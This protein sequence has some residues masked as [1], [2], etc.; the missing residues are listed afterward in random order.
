M[1]AQE[2]HQEQ[3]QQINDEDIVEVV[4]DDGDDIGMDSD[5][6]GDNDKY[7]GEIIIGGPGPGEEDEMM[8][9]EE[10]GEGEQQREDNSVGVN[11]V[12]AEGQ[13][14]FTI[15]LHP[16]FPNPPLAISGGEDDVGFIFCPI[17][18]DPSG[19]LPFTSET[20]TPIKLDGHSDS[21]VNAA[22]NF[23]GEMVAT[24]G[25]DG[26]VVVWQRTKP[27]AAS[28]Q[29]TVEEWSNWQK[30][31][32]LETGT[33]ISWLQWHPKGNVVAA[34]C[35]DATVW[36][37]NLP[38]GNTLNVL[39]AHTMT[40]TVG[41]FTPSGKQLLT[42]SIDSSLILWDPREPSPIWKSSIF[43]PPNWPDLDPSE[44]G[45]TALAVS[46][47]GQIAAVG[48]AG[49]Q[50]KLVGVA[51]GDQLATKLVG[52]AEGESVE[53]LVFVDL[54]NG[55]T[56]GN[57]GVVLVSAATDGKA[58][59]WDVATG[60]V[61]A[62]LSHSEPIT[63]VTAHPFP[64]LHLV[65]TASADSTLKTWDIRTG[66]LVGTHTGHMGVVNGVA[67]APAPGGEGKALVSAGDEGVSLIWKL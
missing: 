29:A 15:A 38:S 35:E 57:K 32:E 37:W 11:S 31:Q 50:V 61:R 33:E 45:I 14:V 7:D 2:D 67:V 53:A 54:L 28:E 58:F 39:S 19:T 21:V 41:L 10:E 66:A 17:P 5:S 62:E 12:H 40:S 27:E 13:S 3:D 42:A 59:V 23:D 22:F 48:S 63:T 34:G 46:P 18:A 1:S 30:I 65:T 47:N 4:E 24:G 44:H 60:R 6:D 56:G 43:T 25:M 9:E 36:L 26:K 20:F 16:S 55:A 52:H 51:K 49:G 8:M 64:Q